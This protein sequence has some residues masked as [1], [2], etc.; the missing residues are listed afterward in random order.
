GV[1]VLGLMEPTTSPGSIDSTSPVPSTTRRGS[2]KTIA[3]QRCSRRSH[4]FMCASVVCRTASRTSRAGA[5][6]ASL[7]GLRGGPLQLE[8]LAERKAPQVPLHHILD[9]GEVVR[10]GR[11][12][13]KRQS[14]VIRRKS[15]GACREGDAALAGGELDRQLVGEV[16]AELLEI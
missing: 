9:A 7:C 2:A 5:G 6:E 10:A 1:S 12:G 15:A 14:G 3:T 8:R 4:A 16:L 11:L 13:P